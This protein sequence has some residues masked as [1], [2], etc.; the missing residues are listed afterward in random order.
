MAIL[1]VE[2]IEFDFLVIQHVSAHNTSFQQS[3]FQPVR[4]AIQ[5]VKRTSL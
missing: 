3:S 2:A 4:P 1:A 5:P